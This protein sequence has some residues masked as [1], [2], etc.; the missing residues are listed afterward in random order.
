MRQRRLLS[1]RRA[2]APER[3]GEYLEH[4]A[5]VRAAVEERGGHAWLFQAAR[6]ESLF[7]EFI[8]W[9][10][11]PGEESLPERQEVGGA[12]RALDVAF[13]PGQ[14]EEWREAPVVAGESRVSERES[15]L[16][17]LRG[18]SVRRGEF[19]LASGARSSYYI[20]ARRTTMSGEGLRLIGR[21]GLAALDGAGWRPD[22]IGGLTLGADPVAY[23]IAHSAALA[24]R[25]LEAFTV[26]KEPKAHGMGRRIEGAFEPGMQ[27]VIAED[28]VT[29]GES[30][31]KAIR[32]VEEEGGRVLGVL[33]VVDREEGGRQRLEGEGYGL[34]ALFTA[35][36]L[37]AE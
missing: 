35:A 16:R 33:A 24:G 20:D 8:E 11:A 4:W 2:V 21:V 19:V 34:V 23:A 31:L 3:V 26:R 10:E 9:K 13:G 37:L 36:E 29:T 25:S 32:A 28:V 5:R 14:E 27:V 6:G 7:M 1:T 18:R 15:L 22:A 30:A 17:L 12:R